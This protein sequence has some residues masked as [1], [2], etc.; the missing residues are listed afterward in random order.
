MTTA[1][2]Y[3]PDDRSIQALGI[4]PDVEIPFIA[5]IQPEDPQANRKLLKEVDLAQHLPGLQ[6]EKD[7]EKDKAAGELEERLQA[8]N[9]LRT[10][11][12]ILKS[13]DLFYKFNNTTN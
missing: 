1:R 10:A 11:Y 8:D 12:N 13:L 4:I 5:C 2:Y 3:T 6:A 9:Q 7:K